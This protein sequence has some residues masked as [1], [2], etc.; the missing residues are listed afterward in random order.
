VT[1]AFPACAVADAAAAAAAAVLPAAGAAALAASFACCVSNYYAALAANL[2]CCVSNSSRRA[3][4]THHLSGY[5]CPAAKTLATPKTT[6]AALV[7]HV[8]SK[9]PQVRIKK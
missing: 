4:N 9:S 2:A 8:R 7:K 5:L 6:L 1:A 3:S